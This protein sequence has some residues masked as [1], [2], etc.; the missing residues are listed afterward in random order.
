MM[1][2]IRS[3]VESIKSNIKLLRIELEAIKS[4]C[5]HPSDKAVIRDINQSGGSSMLRK[6]CYHCGKNLG[7]PSPSE[8]I[9]Y[10]N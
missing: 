6:V 9:K 2:N 7:F 8:V 1:D 5:K 3:K 10:L 4:I